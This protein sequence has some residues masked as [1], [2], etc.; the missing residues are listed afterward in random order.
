MQSLALQDSSLMSRPDFPVLSGFEKGVSVIFYRFSENILKWRAESESET[1]YLW[2]GGE[3]NGRIRHL[4][5]G[6]LWMCL[7]ATPLMFAQSED[8]S[9][10]GQVN[11]PQGAAVAGAV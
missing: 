3:M 10:T 6:I 11:D 4:L 8:G 5:I 2:T 9:I 1:L 7:C